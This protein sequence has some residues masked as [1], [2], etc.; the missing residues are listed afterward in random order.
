MRAAEAGETIDVTV[1]GRVVAQLAP[2]ERD[3]WR[4]WADVAEVWS[5]LADPD[6]ADDR[7]LVDQD[8]LDPFTR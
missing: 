5:G 7:D 6:W 2:V 4:R 1:S 3:H 8:P